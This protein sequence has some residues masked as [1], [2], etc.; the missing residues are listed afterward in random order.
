MFTSASCVQLGKTAA[1]C[2][3]LG[4]K[5]TSTTPKN[6]G[7]YKRSPFSQR[8]ETETKIN[9]QLK[10]L[11]EQAKTLFDNGKGDFFYGERFTQGA[12]YPQLPTIGIW[13]PQYRRLGRSEARSQSSDPPPP[14]KTKSCRRM[15][16]FF[17]N[18]GVVPIAAT[19]LDT[20]PLSLSVP[21]C[22]SRTKVW[23]H[24]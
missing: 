11:K 4:E 3:G 14:P 19:P 20:G 2:Y 7:A 15:R 24:H 12:S 10:I 9:I 6:I 22:P 23:I 16:Y 13:G 1:Q 17:M 18:H 8:T 21:K 5:T